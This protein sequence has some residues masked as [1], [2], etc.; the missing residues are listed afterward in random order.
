[1]LPRYEM[2]LAEIRSSISNLL[3]EIILSS[4]D[5][6]KAFEENKN[7]FYVSARNRLK[8]LQSNANAIDNL[9]IRAFALFG[10]EAN[11]LRTLVAYLKMTNDLERIGDSTYKYAKRLEEHCKGECD[12]SPLT[13]AII[14]LH[15]TTLNALQYIHTCLT[16]TECDADELYR[17]VLV[18][19]SKND[20]LFSLM[21]KDLLKLIIDSDD[22]AVEYVRVLGTLRKLERSGDRAVNIAALLL[23][24]KNGGELHMYN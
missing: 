15:K 22:I 9:V 19:E 3:Q 8:N 14:Q 21:E 13:N 7:E 24:A 2:K 12:L 17:K 11:E 1:M 10:P 18:E 23:F 16:D 6:L 4:E 5:T 20:D